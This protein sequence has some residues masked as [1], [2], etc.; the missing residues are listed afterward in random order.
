MKQYI[1]FYNNY[2]IYTMGRWREAFDFF[3]Y[4]RKYEIIESYDDINEWDEYKREV[5]LDNNK[6]IIIQYYYD[7]WSLSGKTLYDQ[8]GDIVEFYDFRKYEVIT[9][10]I[11]LERVKKI[12]SLLES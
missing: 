12:T 8:F 6:S 10:D 7:G 11:S 2:P 3:E 9:V 5:K 4:D 1:I